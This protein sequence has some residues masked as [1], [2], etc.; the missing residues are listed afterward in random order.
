MNLT[1]ADNKG[2]KADKNLVLNGGEYTITSASE[3]GCAIKSDSLLTIKDGTLTLNISESDNKGIKSDQFIT[4]N[5]GSTTITSTSASSC[6]IKSDS[7]M[8]INDGSI[9]LTISGDGSKGLKSSQDII[10]NGGTI[11]ITHTGATALTES[12]SGYD[13]SYPTAIKTDSTFTINDG[14]ITITSSGVGGKG[15]SSDV[16][17]ITNGGTLTIE[18]S[19][20]G[21]TFTTEDGETD[22]YTAKCLDSDDNMSLLRGTITCSSS[23]TGGKG[24]KTDG[25]LTLGNTSDD[26]TQLILDVATTGSSYSASSSDGSSTGSSSSGPSGSSGGP[27]GNSG[28][29]GSDNGDNHM[30]SDNSS[31]GSSAKA[32]KAEGTITINAGTITIATNTDGAEGLE[33]KTAVTVNGGTFYAK[34]YDDCINTSGIITFNGGFVYCWATGNDAI[35]SNYGATGAVTINDG[36]IVALSTAGSPEEAL[37]CDNNSY[38]KLNG[39]YIFTAGGKMESGSLSNA[40]QAYYLNT[41]SVSYSSS[42]YYSLK[43]ASGNA[44]YSF[45]LPTNVSS[46]L[47]VITAPSMTKGST[48][49]INSGSSAPTGYSN[50]FRDFYI[51]GSCSTSSKIQ[52]FTAVQ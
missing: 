14:T 1:G 19:G 35:D 24:I 27:G 23:G 49:T 52:E 29:P 22:T 32:A 45:K 5:G 34:C 39:G 26:N 25:D 47:S 42:N 40:G 17:I 10:V 18:T 7:T 16:H 20:D 38:M 8:T 51:G 31:S 36:V 12:G 30:G 15:I 3:G 44:I 37:D 43:D 48:Y 21:G 6:G 50:S 28:G 41:S 9:T 11:D 13:P 46:Q 4:I 33:S 2:F